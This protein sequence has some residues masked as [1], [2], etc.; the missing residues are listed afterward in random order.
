MDLPTFLKL[1]FDN[2]KLLCLRVCFCVGFVKI[3]CLGFTIELIFESHVLHRR[4]KIF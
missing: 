4:F 2:Y 3:A 1:D